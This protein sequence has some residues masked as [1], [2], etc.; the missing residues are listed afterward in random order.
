MLTVACTVSA[1]D[2]YSTAPLKLTTP[3]MDAKSLSEDF[4]AKCTEKRTLNIG[5]DTQPT[6]YTDLATPEYRMKDHAPWSKENWT[7]LRTNPDVKPYKMLDDLTFVGVPLFVA[8][9][10]A[11]SEKKSFRQNTKD[12]KH[13]LVT[14]FKTRIDDYAQFFGPTVTTAM[15]IAGLE[16][17][18]D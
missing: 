3:A 17:R 6:P 9:I 16:S 7:L 10:I 5:N 15:K 13:T 12:N 11:K 1:S 18:S 4:K 2:F 14:D 8:G